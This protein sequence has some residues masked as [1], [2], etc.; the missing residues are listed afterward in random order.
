MASQC[1]SSSRGSLRRPK[2]L[3]QTGRNVKR[4]LT[5]VGS[6]NGTLRLILSSSASP[7]CRPPPSRHPPPT[8]PGR[9]IAVIGAA[10]DSPLDVWSLYLVIQIPDHPATIFQHRVAEQ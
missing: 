6:A 2:T 3:F 8:S 9:P 7:P 10:V 4:G 5:P 1:F